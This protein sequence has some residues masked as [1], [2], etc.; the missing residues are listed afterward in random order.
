MEENYLEVVKIKYYT[1]TG[2][3]GDMQFNKTGGKKDLVKSLFSDEGLEPFEGSTDK[4]NIL[5]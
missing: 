1:P 2:L 4:Y 3:Q 5:S